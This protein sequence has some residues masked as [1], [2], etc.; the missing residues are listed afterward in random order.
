MRAKWFCR[1]LLLVAGS[2]NAGFTLAQAPQAKT[3]RMVIPFP[4]GGS[5][6]TVARI[7]APSLSRA[8]GQSV[9][10]D[11]R[12]GAS[13][14]IATSFVARAPADGNTLLIIG[15]S[16]FANAG[17]RSDLPYDTIKDF[18]GVARFDSG[19]FVISVHPSLPAKTIKE[20][21]A[22]ARA[23]PGQL[24]Y[25]TNGNGTGQHLTGEWLKLQTGIDLLHVPYQGGGPSLIAVMGGHAPILMSTVPALVPA[26]AGNKLRPLAVT[27]RVRAEQLKEVPTLAESGLTEFDLTSNL[28]AVVRSGAP[29]ETIDRVSAEMLRAMQVPEVREA[30][31]KAGIYPAPAGPEEFDAIMRADVRKIQKIVKDA[32][33]KLEN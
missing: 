10:V 17:L 11:N 22:F 18:T 29:K 5:N 4:P 20:L 26:L 30:L 3:V 7:L 27:S 9:I 16:W 32:K 28:G 24:A 21:I 13:G 6:D 8:L 14:I 31:L 25:A 1:F 12:P 15:F 2:L 33:I 23:R 19:P